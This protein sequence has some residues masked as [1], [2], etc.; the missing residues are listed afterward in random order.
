MPGLRMPSRLAPLRLSSRRDRGQ[1]C[2]LEEPKY[3]AGLIPQSAVIAVRGEGGGV[4]RHPGRRRN[5]IAPEDNGAGV[6]P[7]SFARREERRRLGQV[8]DRQ[9]GPGSKQNAPD[10]IHY[11]GRYVDDVRY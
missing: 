5:V 3:A 2:V 11:R 9:G 6:G 1:Q 4:D 8:I 10:S 7:Q